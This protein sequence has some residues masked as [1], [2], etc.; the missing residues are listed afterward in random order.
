ME[1][2][3]KYNEKGELVF[4]TK[5]MERLWNRVTGFYGNSG[6]YFKI[7]IGE[8][9]KQST[10]GQHNLFKR[11]CV[12]VSK[13]TGNDYHVVEKEFLKL[14]PFVNKDSLFGIIEERNKR[15]EELNTKE[16][17]EFLEN[18]LLMANDIMGCNLKM[19]HD[20]KLGTIITTE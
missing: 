11:V 7:T 6:S 18:I 20:E 1:F 9:E 3:A 19:Y 4:A 8:L 10:Q 2:L 15:L 17:Q 13:D 5:S 12:M 14:T 16:F